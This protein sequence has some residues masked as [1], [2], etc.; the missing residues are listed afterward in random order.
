MYEAQNFGLMADVFKEMNMTYYPFVKRMAGLF[1]FNVTDDVF[2]TM[3][4]MTRVFDASSVDRFLGRPLP[5]GFTEAD[6]LNV[7]H[8]TSFYYYIAMSNNNSL[9]VN[10][11]KFQKL[12][13]TF[14]L[15]TKL[16]STYSLKWTHLSGHDTD[17]L[18]MHLALNISNAACT[19]ELYRKGSTSAV[20][21]EQGGVDYAGNVIIELHSNNAKD[22]FI[23]VRS[24]GKYMKICSKASYECDYAEFKSLIRKSM[25]TKNMD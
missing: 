21:C 4:T 25:T 6:Y 5:E 14:D 8:L 24:N 15:R 20:E 23:K 13:N 18:A 22:F 2:F 17:I 1:Q 7:R 19:E 12:I 16:P 3:K 10:T 11:F 9:M